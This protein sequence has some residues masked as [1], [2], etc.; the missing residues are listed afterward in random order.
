MGA[1]H[2]P[3]PDFRADLIGDGSSLAID[4]SCKM[5]AFVRV[6]DAACLTGQA[7]K[8][9]HFTSLL[10][11]IPRVSYVRECRA[12][13]SH[14]MRNTTIYRSKFDLFEERQ[15]L[16]DGRAALLLVEIEHPEIVGLL[17]FSDLD[18]E[19]QL[20]EDALMALR[21]IASPE[22]Y[23]RLADEINAME[24]EAAVGRPQI[25]LL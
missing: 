12:V 19:I 7:D 16:A 15:E 10:S 14:I 18:E 20:R 4:L 9:A 11:A 25:I 6:K 23:G 5:S 17:D 21:L 1:A 2:Q 13:R 22:V 24:A 8:S 3:L